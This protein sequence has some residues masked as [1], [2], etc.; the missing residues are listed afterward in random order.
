[1][2]KIMIF[3]GIL[4]M[5]LAT[6]WA[7]VEPNI[8]IVGTD[9]NPNSRECTA[10]DNYLYCFENPSGVHRYN[11]DDGT[12]IKG[13]DLNESYD[14]ATSFVS[15]GAEYNECVFN[16]ADGYIYCLY[17]LFV[18]AGNNTAWKYNPSTH[19]IQAIERHPIDTGSRPR[20]GCDLKPGTDEIWCLYSSTAQDP[21]Y[22]TMYDISEDSWTT[23]N[24]YGL[25]YY[26]DCVFRNSEE[27]WC[28]EFYDPSQPS[29]NIIIYYPDTNTTDDSKTMASATAG[30]YCRWFNDVF[31]C[32]G[33]DDGSIPTAEILYYNP[34]D[35]SSGIL[36]T[37]INPTIAAYGGCTKVNNSLDVCMG[38][39]YGE[40]WDTATDI[41]QIDWGP[42]PEVPVEIPAQQSLDRDN[43]A[44]FVQQQ[45][46][47]KQAQ[48]V[49]PI[50]QFILNLRAFIF[51]LFG[52][53]G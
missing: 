33:G 34:G 22:F 38:Y 18:E 40:N 10:I 3:L 37:M 49:N 43:N 4:L 26:V 7:Q 11:V 6:V 29:D 2:K 24:E 36:N 15:V 12:F 30:G 35:D 1:M 42:L 8:S 50:E 41:L 47:Q 25:V 16:E 27:L 31:Y 28:H 45:Q 48:A 5:M 51:N 52:I 39:Y 13:W 14:P 53:K 19:D 46:R 9:D 20:W 21:S 23:P 32:Y 44:F 17:N